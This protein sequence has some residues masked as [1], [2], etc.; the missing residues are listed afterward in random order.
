MNGN[1][2]LPGFAAYAADAKTL[3]FCCTSG[4]CESCRDSQAV[5]S[6]LLVS[7]PHFLDSKERLRTWVDVAEGYWRQFVKPNLQ[8]GTAQLETARV[9]SKAP[10]IAGCDLQGRPLKLS[11]FNDRVVLLV[12]WDT[13]DRPA[14]R[15]TPTS[16]RSWRSCA[17]P[18]SPWWE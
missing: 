9:G 5:Y 14:A 12:F 17:T 13:G 8:L 1:P 11:R 3:N 6:W 4:H 18:R 15:T 2:V 7:L 10:E 16:G